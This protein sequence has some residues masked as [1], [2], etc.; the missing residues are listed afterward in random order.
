[1]ESV[2]VGG[3]TVVGVFLFIFFEP[4]HQAAVTADAVGRQLGSGSSQAVYQ[5]IIGVQDFCG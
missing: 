3:M 2:Q 1:M 5:G 4:F